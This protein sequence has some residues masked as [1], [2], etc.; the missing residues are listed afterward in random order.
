MML[1]CRQF[2]EHSITPQQRL[3]HSFRTEM[4]T[5]WKSDG[6]TYQGNKLLLGKISS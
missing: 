4:G 2:V 6:S 5:A 3:L 1:D